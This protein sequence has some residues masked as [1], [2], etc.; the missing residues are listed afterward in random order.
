MKLKRGGGGD[1][2]IKVGSDVRARA[3]GI[4]GINF[5]PGIRFWEVNFARALNIPTDSSY[6]LRILRCKSDIQVLAI[7]VD[8]LSLPQ[9][10]SV[11]G[12]RKN[13]HL[14]VMRI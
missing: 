1:S 12:M 5:C 8:L 14:C 2:L 4:L 9:I 7:A 6:D 10:I 3:L 13:K 11:F